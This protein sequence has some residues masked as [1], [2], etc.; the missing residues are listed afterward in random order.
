MKKDQKFA[1][2]PVVMMS[3][4]EGTEIIAS[5]VGN[6]LFRIRSEGLPGQTIKNQCGEGPQ[7]Q[8]HE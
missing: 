5:C 2:L 4:N 3:A 6:F 7:S 1:D 8:V